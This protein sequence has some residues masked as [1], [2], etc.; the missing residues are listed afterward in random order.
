M[1]KRNYTVITEGWID[2]RYRK[3]GE[4]LFMT[5]REAKYLVMG[6]QVSLGVRSS[7]PF[8][9]M[10]APPDQRNPFDHNDSGT[11]GG[12][13][14]AAERD[15]CDELRAEYFTVTGNQAY[16]RW[17]EPRLRAEIAKARAA[18]DDGA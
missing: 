10:V 12:S 1:T 17:G 3:A 15:V 9:T 8:A 18:E 11:P 14:P 5:D 13:L 4:V 16:R 2:G 6:G 7:A